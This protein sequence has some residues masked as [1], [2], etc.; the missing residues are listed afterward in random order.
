MAIPAHYDGWSHFRDGENGM[1]AAIQD[2]PLAVRQTFRWLPDGRAID[3]TE[4]L[5]SAYPASPERK[6]S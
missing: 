5:N 3:L 6:S 4:Q 1:R 2:A